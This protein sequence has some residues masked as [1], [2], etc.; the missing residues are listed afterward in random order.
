VPAL[1]V[2]ETR[3]STSF[4]GRSTGYIEARACD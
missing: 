2:T 4:P 1:L 3:V